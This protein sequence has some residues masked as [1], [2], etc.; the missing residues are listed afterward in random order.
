MIIRTL[1]FFIGLTML[2]LGI[3]VVTHAG[4][5]TGTISAVALVLKEA[6]PL[7][8]GTFV[9]L[10]NVFFFILQSIV[11]PKH[12]FTKF[13]KQIPICFCFGL[14]FDVAFGLTDFIH[15]STYFMQIVTV[16]IGSLFTGLGIAAM[17]FARLAILPPEGLVLCIINRWG[18]TFGNLRVCLDI[19]L[20]VVAA[21]L[22]MI[23]LGSIEGLREGTLITA[24]CSGQFAKVFLK[25]FGKLFPAHRPIE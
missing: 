25:A 24:L 6:Y 21:S 18:G 17:V 13:I 7:S 16:F 4:L 14:I 23:L 11:D 19:F 22:S 2:S 1:I 8:M 5:G 15:P 3:S 20:V 12:L 9:F 10:T